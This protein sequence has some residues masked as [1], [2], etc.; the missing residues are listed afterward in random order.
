MQAKSTNSIFGCFSY[1]EYLK[2]VITSLCVWLYVSLNAKNVTWIFNND[3]EEMQE[4]LYK[5]YFGCILGLGHFI[6]LQKFWLGNRLFIS[7]FS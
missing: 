5:M 1:E 3:I 6:Y 2:R 7:I 4:L